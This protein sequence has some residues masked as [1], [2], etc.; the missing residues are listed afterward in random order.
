[1]THGS[2]KRVRSK[3]LTIR[4][5]PEER[6]ALDGHAARAGITA[7]SYARKV[8][9]DAPPPRGARR[10]PIERR[11]LVRLLGELGKVGSNINQL[12]RQAN[13]G[14]T[15]VRHDLLI[16]LGDLQAMRDALLTA[17]GRD[18]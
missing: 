8:L 16:A 17:L 11:E 7:G 12:A 5:S 10:P 6:A 15:V 2:E 3:H 13:A 14:H 18:P 4:F 1:M 9:L